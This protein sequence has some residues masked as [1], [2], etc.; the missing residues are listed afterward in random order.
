MFQS[1]INSIQIYD[2]NKKVNPFINEYLNQKRKLYVE[3]VNI[4]YYSDET[5]IINYNELKDD[6][7]L[8][9]LD[10]SVIKKNINEIDLCHI[11]NF[12]I[13]FKIKNNKFIMEKNSK[14]KKIIRNIHNSKI[15]NKDIKIDE[16]ENNMIEI[17]PLKKKK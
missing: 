16:I 9:D 2:Y 11:D 12:A 6:S 4:D 1:T 5:K 13:A 15:L 7:N 17:I 10:N 8:Y 3:S 14:W